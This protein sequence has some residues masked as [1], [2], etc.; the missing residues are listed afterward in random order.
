MAQHE[1]SRHAATLQPISYATTEALPGEQ[2]IPDP[3]LPVAYRI[4][5]HRGRLTFET[6]RE[7]EIFSQEANWQFGSGAQGST[8]LGFS[9]K[10][11]V[12]SP[13]SFYRQTGWDFTV[14]FLGMTPAERAQNPTGTLMTPA[15]A[16]RCF[17][18]H[19]TGLREDETG[20]VLVG[21]QIGVQCESCHGPGARHIAEARQNRPTGNIDVPGRGGARE[22]AA[23]CGSCHRSTLPDGVEESHPVTVR[24][25]PWGLLQSECFKKSD[26]KL[27]CASCHNVHGNVVRENSHYNRVCAGCHESKG[28]PRC[29]V[30]PEGNC[31]ACHM[32]RQ[33]VQ[34]NSIFTDHWIRVVKPGSDKEH[35]SAAES[36]RRRVE[37][38]AAALLGD[39]APPGYLVPPG[40]P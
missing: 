35:P 14:G 21:A 12:E 4:T 23:F 22:M 16:A 1:Q 8:F 11:W 30:E 20:P 25:A 33:I 28:D 40:P 3:D 17:R 36:R 27:S 38:I 31:V 9:P 2:W 15:D 10:G 32:P 19:T 6:E 37:R 18:C 5:T 24:F 29:P 39:P 26:D 7:G 13:L 34:R